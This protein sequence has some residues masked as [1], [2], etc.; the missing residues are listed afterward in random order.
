M[1]GY[2]KLRKAYQA[3][4]NSDFEQ[5]AFWFEKAIES[6]PDNADYHY[7]LSITYSRSNKLS[8]ALEHAEA[9]ARLDP[10][11]ELYRLQV[12]T[13]QARELVVQAE[14]SL[15]GKTAQP[16]L[17]IALLRQ[18]VSLDPL[19][20]EAFLLLGV[21]S[22]SASDYAQAVQALHEA[23]RLDPQQESALS[24]LPVYERKLK[25]LL[26]TDQS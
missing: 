6:E 10:E 19:S 4:L 23:L 21:S 26:G 8:K 9:A 11:K 17:A 25:M 15:E 2:H 13:L 1:K 18:A 22:A 7:R 3:I 16:L 5:A 14:K 20:V 24:L 12:A